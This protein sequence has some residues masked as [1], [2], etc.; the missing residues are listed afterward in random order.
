MV[1]EA[2]HAVVRLLGDV[3]SGP[4]LLPELVGAGHL[5]RSGAGHGLGVL[6]LSG[7]LYGFGLFQFGIYLGGVE[8]DEG[9]AGV[10]MVALAEAVGLDAPGHLAG[11]AHLGG[12]GL[13]H[14][15]VVSWG[16]EEE[17]CQCH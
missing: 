4:S 8:V 17:A 2:L 10:H 14:D 15:D 13:T 7:R 1:E 11:D 6:C 5:L 9:V 3:E 12:F 16:E